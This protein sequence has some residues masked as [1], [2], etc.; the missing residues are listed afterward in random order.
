MP[1][2]RET[3]IVERID[4]AEGLWTI[5]LDQSLDFQPGQFVNIGIDVAGERVKRSYSVAS[6]PGD[7]VE[8]FL[9]RVSGGALS[10]PLFDLQQ[11][12]RLWLEDRAYGLLT[13]EH[14]P[15]FAK[16]LWLLATGTGL[17]PFLSML[18]SGV[19]LPRF[20]RVIVV[21]C[22]R[23]NV[24]LAYQNELQRL[25]EASADSL[26]YVPFVTREPP[27]Q[28]RHAGRI[29]AAIEDGRLESLAGVPFDGARSHFMLCGNP[30][31]I[32]DAIEKLAARGLKRHR[33]RDPGHITI[34][35]YW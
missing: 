24:H 17:A 23:L 31:M 5:R 18:R 30:E 20:E 7:P 33:R 4:W 25:C 3:T 34:E 11:G 16:D 14:V 26:R 1:G 22:V 29:T 35:K 8:L 19:L 12:A 32:A 21:N 9:A 27:L 2:W 13:L 10:T 15:A 6:A 28:G